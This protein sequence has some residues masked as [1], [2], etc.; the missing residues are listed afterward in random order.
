MSCFTPPST[1]T[2]IDRGEGNADRVTLLF[3]PNVAD[4]GFSAVVT[5]QGDSLAGEWSETSFVGPVAMGAYR[6]WRAR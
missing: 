1:S 6:M 4:C 3:T 2:L 5:G